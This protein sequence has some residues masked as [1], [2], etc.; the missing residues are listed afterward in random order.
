MTKV[1]YATTTFGTHTKR[2]T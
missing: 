1:S 2:R